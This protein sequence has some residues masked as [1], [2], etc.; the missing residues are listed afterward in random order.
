M[1]TPYLVSIYTKCEAGTLKRTK[2]E[3]KQMNRETRRKGNVHRMYL[4]REDRWRK[5][6]GRL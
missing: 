1:R 2:E 3:I 6:S 4:L 5:S